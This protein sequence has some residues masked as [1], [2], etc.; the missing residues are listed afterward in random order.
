MFYYS[1][2]PSS[3]SEGTP[4]CKKRKRKN[5]MQKQ[6]ESKQALSGVVE[7]NKI[8]CNIAEN[9]CTDGVEASGHADVSM[10]PINGEDPSCAQSNA[11]VA[12]ILVDKCSENSS[13]FQESSAGRKRRKKK[14]KKGSLSRGQDFSSENG[15]MV[16]KNSLDSSMHHDVSCICAS[17]LVDAR[18]E[19]IKNIYSPRGS[20]VRFQ[21]KKLLILDLNGLLADINQDFH[22]ADKAHAKVRGKLGNL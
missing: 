1:C 20:L 4:K 8:V 5:K 21:R 10:D 2:F 6:P 13:L 14:R 9:G 19:K 3:A 16:G 12:G 7:V 22:S 15:G 17:C 18:K 11:S